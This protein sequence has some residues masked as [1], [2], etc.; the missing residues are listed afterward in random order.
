MPIQLRVVLIIA[1]LATCY[2]TLHKIRKSQIKIEDALFWILTSISLVL[3]SIF[4]SIAFFFADLLVI[5][6]SVNF[7]YLVV[8]FFL[9]LKVFVLSIK[10]SQME[11]RIKNL[12]QRIAIDQD[13]SKKTLEQFESIFKIYKEVASTVEDKNNL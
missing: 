5:D 9:I 12:V 6:S 13:E 10:L 4:P 8:I 2:Y 7:V 1:S 11:E 3:L